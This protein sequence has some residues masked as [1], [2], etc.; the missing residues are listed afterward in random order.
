LAGA[1]SAGADVF[2]RE[3]EALV[4]DADRVG[5]GA[6]E[7]VLGALAAGAGSAGAAAFEL[8]CEALPAGA[9]AFVLGFAALVAGALV[10]GA[11]VLD[12]GA[13][14]AGAGCAVEAFGLECDEP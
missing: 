8:E 1:D 14:V 4:G 7:L 11:L 13:V 12:F 6:F 2:E 10:A 9:D 3:C 5:A